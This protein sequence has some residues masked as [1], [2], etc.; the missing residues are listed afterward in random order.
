MMLL[1]VIGYFSC[2]GALDREELVVAFKVFICF[3]KF[4]VSLPYDFSPFFFFFCM[5]IQLSGIH[6]TKYN[7]SLPVCMFA[8]LFA[9]IFFI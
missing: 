8:G 2:E 6:Q 9:L 1:S 5:F 4:T 7:R 3:S